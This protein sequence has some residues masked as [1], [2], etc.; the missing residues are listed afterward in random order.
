ML[1]EVQCESVIQSSTGLKIKNVDL[2]VP[3]VKNID[4]FNRM[5]RIAEEFI[6]T[7]FFRISL[8]EV[9]VKIHLMNY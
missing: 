1:S 3:R 8:L 9:F 2:I 6:F 7:N 5:N 4:I